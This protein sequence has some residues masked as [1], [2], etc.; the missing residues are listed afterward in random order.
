M[1]ASPSSPRTGWPVG[2][3]GSPSVM[4]VVFVLAS[5]TDVVPGAEVMSN[6]ISPSG[7][8]TMEC[9]REPS[10]QLS[11]T[12]SSVWRISSA[13]CGRMTVSAC[14][15]ARVWTMASLASMAAS[16]RATIS[17]LPGAPPPV[18]AS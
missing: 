13:P 9:V 1:R 15:R 2:V 6:S 8:R 11:V 17:A 3:C 18:T 16:A 4:V 5:Q 14:S 12:W 7:E 10:A